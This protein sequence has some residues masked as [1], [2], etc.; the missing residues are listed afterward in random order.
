LRTEKP[1]RI[2]GHGADL[3][4]RPNGAGLKARTTA[5]VVIVLLT[6]ACRQDMHDQPTLSALEAT[7]FFEDRSAS[8]LPVEGTVARGELR[9]DELLYTGMM[10]DEPAAVFPFPVDDAVMARGQE[11]FNAFCS[12][13]HGQTGAGDGMVVQR[14]FTRPPD[15]ADVRLREAPVGHIFTV[16]TNGFGAMPDHAAQ[17]RVRDRWAITAYVR[18]LQLARAATLDDV[19]PAERS[20]LEGMPATGGTPPQ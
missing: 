10:G 9:E 17:I 8:R 18:A 4:V 2:C 1:L 19:P 14:G 16:I 3:Q 6:V 20:K 12:H 7:P 13:C 15:L 5:V 11:M